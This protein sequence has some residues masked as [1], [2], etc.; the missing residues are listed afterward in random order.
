MPVICLPVN[1]ERSRLP[2]FG[3]SRFSCAQWYRGRA[4]EKVGRF[5]INEDFHSL[6]IP[7]VLHIPRFHRI[8][9]DF[10][11]CGFSALR[12]FLSLPYSFHLQI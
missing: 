11:I 1:R 2:T 12:L 9:M 4:T 7:L 8:P 6:F 3:L 10:A 5:P